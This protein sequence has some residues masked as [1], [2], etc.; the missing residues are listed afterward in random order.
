MGSDAQMGLHM[1]RQTIGT[2]ELLAADRTDMVLCPGVDPHVRCQI[3]GTRED[4][5]AGR[6][7]VHL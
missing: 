3:T 5:S 7:H 6:T 4:H 2:A 1:N